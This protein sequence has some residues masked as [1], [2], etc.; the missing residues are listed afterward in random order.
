MTKKNKKFTKFF[1]VSN[2]FAAIILRVVFSVKGLQEF[3]DI[4]VSV[5]ITTVR[6]TEC[7]SSILACLT[8]RKITEEL[9]GNH[10]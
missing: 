7:P 2:K 4:I 9:L 10:W 6:N 3:E 1:R 5:V 8:M